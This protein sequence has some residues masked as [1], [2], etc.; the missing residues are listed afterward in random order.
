M[1][2]GRP[3]Q[4][5]RWGILSDTSEGKMES[6][7]PRQFQLMS[8]IVSGHAFPWSLLILGLLTSCCYRHH[9]FMVVSSCECYFE[10]PTRTLSCFPLCHAGYTQVAILMRVV[11]PP[12]W[13]FSWGALLCYRKGLSW[14]FSPKP[15]KKQDTAEFF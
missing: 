12:I 14:V 8:F 11:R 10:T 5:G 9:S 2:R 15:S 3:S 13:S 7:I 4:D 1:R 6:H